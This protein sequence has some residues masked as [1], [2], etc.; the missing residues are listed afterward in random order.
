M[1]KLLTISV[2]LLGYLLYTSFGTDENKPVAIQPSK[3][4]MG[5]VEKGYHYLIAGDYLKSG[6]PLKIY[7][8]AN[9]KDTRN[10]LVRDSLNKDISYEY[11]VMQAPN[12]ETI[13][14][15]NCLQCHAQVFDDKLYIGL[16][17]NTM[18][19][20]ESKSQTSRIAGLYT[21][22]SVTGGKKFEAAK[23]FLMASKTVLPYLQTE[24]RG[25]NAADRLAAILAAHRDPVTFKWSSKPLLNISEEVVP[26]DV[27]AWWL[28][29]KKNAMFYNGFGR[30]DFSK[31][32][33]A[34]NLLTVNDTV[35]SR[36]VYT[37]F[38]DVLAYIYSIQSPKYPSPVNKEL[39]ATGQQLFE[40]NCSRCHGMGDQYPNLLIPASIIKTDSALYSSNYSSPQ[41]VEW[42]NKSWFTM[43]ANPAQLVPFK[44]Y[45]APPLDGVWITAPYLHNG[46]VPTL[47]ALL[48]SKL[49]PVFWKRDFDKQ[50]YDYE[51][52][53]WKYS[54]AAADE[55][56]AYNTTKYGYS[57]AGHY[58]G[59]KLTNAER[60]AIIEY[61]KI[62]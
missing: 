7:L 8:M 14:A 6:I 47:E 33:M 17:N 60:K 9:G 32:L 52:I 10:L 55:H 18:D 34:S 30:G 58:F 26:T 22:M 48:N 12:G 29:K 31:F 39:A 59:D 19:F 38:G 46:S 15:P 42:F 11:T 57:N 50:E 28:L 23:N 16:G 54:L 35:E 56:G 21:F 2:L 44:G 40:E 1:K 36:E 53:G 24:S 62:L 43:G 13:V 49:R 5:D 45:I 25:V 20:T 3:Q 61:L 37:H 41:F 51:H 4:R 27:P